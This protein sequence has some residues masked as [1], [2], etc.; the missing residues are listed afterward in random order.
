MNVFEKEGFDAAPEVTAE[1]MEK[2][3]KELRFKDK[4]NQRE[5][6]QGGWKLLG[7][8]RNKKVKNL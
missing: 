4:F 8:N 5:I 3:E 2:R 7:L 1:E 6:L